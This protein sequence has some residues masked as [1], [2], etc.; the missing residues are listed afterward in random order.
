M[1]NILLFGAGQMGNVHARAYS[2]SGLARVAAVIEPNETRGMAFA[3]EHGCN[4]CS[5]AQTLPANV[6]VDAA[7]ICLPTHLHAAAVIQAADITPYVL[8]EKPLCLGKEALREIEAA[9][10]RTKASLMVAH[11][12]RFWDGYAALQQQLETGVIGPVHS[13]VVHRR[14]KRPQWSAQN[15]LFDSKKSGG[16][17]YDLAIHDIDWLV[18]RFGLPGEVFAQSTEPPEVHASVMLLWPRQNLL[19]T[20]LV[21]WAM[22]D[23]MHEGHMDCSM[24]LVGEKGMLVYDANRPGYLVETTGQPRELPYQAYCAYEAELAYFCECVLTGALPQKADLAS[25]TA[26]LRV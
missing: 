1:L 19:A 8:C 12:V 18:C 15:W 3:A 24:E 21:S 14:Q 9:L 13:A 7:D 17:I 16:I 5:S 4:W 23:E 25:A 2:A 6:K 22:P 26:T 10:T 20:V 11:V